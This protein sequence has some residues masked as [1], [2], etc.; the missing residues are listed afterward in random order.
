MVPPAN[1]FPPPVADAAALELDVVEVVRGSGGAYWGLHVARRA[2]NDATRTLR[3]NMLKTVRLCRY[4]RSASLA[5]F[6]SYTAAHPSSMTNLA[7]V[8]L[9]RRSMFNNSILRTVGTT[10]GDGHKTFPF[11]FT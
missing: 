5:D 8:A 1:P 6:P 3:P 4:W 10:A 11:S 7:K 2:K 9:L